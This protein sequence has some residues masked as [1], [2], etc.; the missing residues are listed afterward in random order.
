MGTRWVS[1]RVEF[2]CNNES[3]VAVLTSGSSRDHSLVVLGRYLSLLAIRYSFSLTI[4]SFRSKANQ[5]WMLFLVFN[6]SGSGSPLYMPLKLL[7][8]FQPLSCQL[9]KSFDGEV[10]V[11]FTHALAP[12][13]RRIYLSTQHCSI[14]FYRQD[15]HVSPDGSLRPADE[16]TLVRFSALLADGMKHSSIK[17][18]PSAVRSLHI[19][20]GFPDLLVTFFSYSNC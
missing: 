15:G 8:R 19:D 6:F 2:M 16:Q 3:V 7:Q 17:V 14:N 13:T 12:S 20:K 4:S 5:W 9:C 11:F 18:Y 10:S 1:Q